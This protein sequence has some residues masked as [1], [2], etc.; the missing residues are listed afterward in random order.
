MIQLTETIAIDEDAIALKPIHASGPGGQHVNKNL[1]AIQL[2]FDISQGC[3]LSYEL[4]QRLIEVAGSRVNSA[5]QLVITARRHRSQERNRREA[6][7]RLFELIRK[8]AQKPRPRIKRRR[9]QASHQA[10]L[11]AKRRQG[12][13][14]QQRQPVVVC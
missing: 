4:R 1:T 3:G 11:N 9:S 12:E 5:Q 13:K 10:R 8:A 14:K 6:F 2:R 7:E